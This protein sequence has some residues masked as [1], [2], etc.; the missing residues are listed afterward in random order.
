MKQIWYLSLIL[1]AATCFQCNV[2]DPTPDLP[3]PPVEI[4]T[5]VEEPAACE[6]AE[7]INGFGFDLFRQL[8][9]DA[10][11]ENI[12]LSPLSVSAALSMTA[13][14][15][16]NNT[17]SQMREVLHQNAMTE[18]EVNEAFKFYLPALIDIDPAVTMLPANSIWYDELFPVYPEFLATNQTYFDAQVEALDFRDPDAA[19]II[20]SW[21]EDNTNGKITEMLQSIPADAVM[22]LINAIYFKGDWRFQFEE[23]DTYDA[24]FNNLAGQEENTPMMSFPEGADLPY[25]QNAEVQLLD[26]PFADSVYSMTLMLP[27][28]DNDLDGLIESLTPANWTAWTDALQPQEVRVHLPRFTLEYEEK[29]NDA[30]TALGMSDAFN[31]DLCNLDR[32]SSDPLTY[33]SMVKHKSFLEVNEA[34]SEAA[35]VTVVEIG[36]NSVSG[37]TFR[38]DEPFLLVIR[39][40]AANGALFVGKVGSLEE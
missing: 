37:Y 39:E 33:I 32:L 12:F 13:N 26:L 17:L 5:C 34:G 15:A 35:A 29:L 16:E 1:F 3:D 18:A 7:S 8:H 2:E 10:P 11:L 14:G 38:C 30:L 36:T 4:F 9:E 25:Y 23:E 20:N 31:R 24:V 27:N 19:S 22:Y 28:G 40:R 21:I 6:L